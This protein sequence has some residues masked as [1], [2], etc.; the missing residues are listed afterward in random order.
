MSKEGFDTPWT[1]VSALLEGMLRR[2]HAGVLA[3]RHLARPREL[4]QE[5][6]GAHTG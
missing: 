6:A 5:S 4:D 1:R 2:L 3:H